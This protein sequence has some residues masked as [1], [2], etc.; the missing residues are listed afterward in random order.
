MRSPERSASPRSS[1]GDSPDPVPVLRRPTGHQRRLCID[2][3]R[4]VRPQGPTRS[5][6]S[7]RSPVDR[8]LASRA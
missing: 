1:D 2:A 4:R 6:N 5:Q 8:G 3:K 7:R